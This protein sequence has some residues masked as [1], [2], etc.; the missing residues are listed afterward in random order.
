MTSEKVQPRRRAAAMAAPIGT[1]LT[2]RACGRLADEAAI[3][4]AIPGNL[5]GAISAQP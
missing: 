5:Y 1:H 2:S 3:G 4:E